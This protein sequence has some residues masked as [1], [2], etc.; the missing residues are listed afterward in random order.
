MTASTTGRLPARA[1][2]RARSDA[3]INVRIPRFVREL[4][5]TAAAAVGQ[6]R[7]EFV[8]KSAERHALNVLLD[9]RFFQLDSGQHKAFLRVLENPPPPSKKLKELLSSKAP[10]ES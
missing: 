8:I 7:S 10:W 1:R 6:S 2:T 9:Q 5:D 3:V 4:I